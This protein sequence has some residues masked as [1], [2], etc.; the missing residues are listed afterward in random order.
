MLLRTRPNV[1][2][3]PR[4]TLQRSLASLSYSSSAPPSA[5]SSSPLRH[6]RYAYDLYFHP[7]PASSSLSSRKPRT[8]AVS[9]FEEDVNDERVIGWVL[10]GAGEEGGVPVLRPGGWE[11]RRGFEDVL[12]E[13][14]KAHVG[15]DQGIQGLAAH[16]KLGYLNINDERSPA[17]FGR[18]SDPE[19]ILG[20]VRLDNGSII[21]G[22]YERFPTHRLVTFN[23]MFLL[24]TYLH[25]KLLERLRRG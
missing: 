9:F 4:L 13:V 5:P 23:G 2:A 21:P 3:L 19:D 15:E 14:L 20:A 7:Q 16:Q 25:Q 11:G 18:V 24:S 17:P 1:P 6:P 12:H 10:A 8:H 22:S